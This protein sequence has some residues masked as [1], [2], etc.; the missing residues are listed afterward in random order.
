MIWRFVRLNATLV[1]T[2]VR[3]FGTGTNANLKTS[4]LCFIELL[5]PETFQ[6]LAILISSRA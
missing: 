6:L 4:L 3:S 2:F 5:F 1:L